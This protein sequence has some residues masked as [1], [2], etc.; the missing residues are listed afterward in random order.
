[1][2]TSTHFA[3][4]DSSGLKSVPLLI[5]PATS[6]LDH[7]PLASAFLPYMYWGLICELTGFESCEP[8]INNH[9][10]EGWSLLIPLAGR[11]HPTPHIEPVQVN[12]EWTTWSE[13][14]K[15]KGKLLSNE[16]KGFFIRRDMQRRRHHQ[17]SFT[18]TLFPQIFTFLS[19]TKRT[20]NYRALSSLPLAS[21]EQGGF[22][23]SY[24]MLGL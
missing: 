1:M 2:R 6:D 24:L 15:G 10:G 8:N 11:L 16:R 23:E 18:A 21:S 12:P 22:D 7:L 20:A 5:K 3:A 19:W 13:R 14:G 17:I 9:H 4:R